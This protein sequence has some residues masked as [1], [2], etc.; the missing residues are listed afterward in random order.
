MTPDPTPPASLT[1]DELEAIKAQCQTYEAAAIFSRGTPSSE[2]ERYTA[3]CQQERTLKE[4]LLRCVAEIERLH[5]LHSK[6]DPDFTVRPL[7]PRQYE[8]GVGGYILPPN[9]PER[10]RQ[11][12]L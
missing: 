7:E 1:P 3:K 8:R 12:V 6:G 10:D 9:M 4:T 11:E 2:I 5:V